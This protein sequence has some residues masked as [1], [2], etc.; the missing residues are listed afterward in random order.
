MFNSSTSGE[1]AAILVGR[2]WEHDVHST[3]TVN[4]N[5]RLVITSTRHY[6]YT[7]YLRYRSNVL[8][9]LDLCY[10]QN[11]PYQYGI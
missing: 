8:Y 9:T 11:I 7:L 3:S 2:K 4:V 6:V 10:N 1:M 5:Q